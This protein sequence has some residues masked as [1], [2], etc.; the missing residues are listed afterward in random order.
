M[1]RRFLCMTAM[2]FVIIYLTVS[3]YFADRF[4]HRLRSKGFFSSMHKRNSKAST[5]YRE[6][7]MK[8]N[9]AAKSVMIATHPILAPVME[10]NF[11]QKLNNLL[12]SDSI[13]RRP[14]DRKVDFK[15]MH[16]TDISPDHSPSFLGKYAPLKSTLEKTGLKTKSDVCKHLVSGNEQ[17]RQKA[18]RKLKKQSKLSHRTDKNISLTFNGCPEIYSYINR[19][20]SERHESIQNRPIAYSIVLNKPLDQSFQLLRAI[21]NPSNTYCL[22]VHASAT[23]RYFATINKLAKCFQN[24]LISPKRFRILHATID[25]VEAHLSC[26]R[27]LLNST[28]SWRYLISIPGSVFP[29][30]NNTV[31]LDYLEKRGYLNSITYGDA[32]SESF[33]RRT[34]FVHEYSVNW[35]GY[36]IFSK[37]TRTKLPPPENVTIFRGDSSFLATRDFAEYSLTSR[38]AQDLLEWSRDTKNPEG[39]YWATLNRVPGA[40]GG[41]PHRMDTELIKEDDTGIT[42]E[43][44]STT[45]ESDLIARLWRTQHNHRCGGKYTANLCVFNYKDL[46]WLLGQDCLFADSFDLKIDN[47]VINCLYKNLK[48]PLVEDVDMFTYHETIF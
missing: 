8:R 44:I 6:F 31:L 15:E 36:E 33:L 5:R 16:S 24:I 41:T 18:I 46:R 20:F 40:P 9:R 37:T 35:R 34:Q 22:H 11:T 17:L 10:Q 23:K 13:S 29:L 38:I 1:G 42:T 14:N 48:K 32:T 19:T 45:S 3:I 21:Y 27:T 7:G 12:Q 39:F 43:D 4:L 47:V 30:R 26:F 2:L 25:R 28:I